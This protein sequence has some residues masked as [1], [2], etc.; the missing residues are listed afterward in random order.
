MQGSG[1]PLG[2]RSIW[3]RLLVTHQLFVRRQ[4]IL[5]YIVLANISLYYNYIP[6]LYNTD[7]VMMLLVST[8][9]KRRVY[10]SKVPSYNHAC[11]GYTIAMMIV[12]SFPILKGSKFH[13][14]HRWL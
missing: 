3:Y 9:L 4:V 2:Y 13:L 12:I 6:L 7:T 11:I 1:S 14:V 5:F 10:R 8:K